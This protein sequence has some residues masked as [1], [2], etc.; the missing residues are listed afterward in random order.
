MVANSTGSGATTRLRGL[1]SRIR[2]IAPIG[3]AMP[4]IGWTTDPNGYLE[5]PGSRQITNGPVGLR[6]GETLLR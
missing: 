2:N 6:C 5:M 4:G 3:C 1:R